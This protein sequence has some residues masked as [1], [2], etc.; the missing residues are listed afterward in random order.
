[1]PYKNLEKRKL[2]HRDYY[3]DYMSNQGR[4]YREKSNQKRQEEIGGYKKDLLL[5][6]KFRRIQKK[7]GIEGLKAFERDMFSCSLCGEWDFRVLEMHELCK[8]FNTSSN[9]RTLCSNCHARV[10]FD[11]GEQ[12]DMIFPVEYWDSHFMRVAEYYGR[13]SSCFSQKYG[14]V[15]VNRDEFNVPY[16]VSIGRNGPPIGFPHCN[17][18]NPNQEEICSR[19]L[20]G[21]KSGEGL[22]FCPAAH[23]ESNAITFAAREGRCTDQSTLYGNFCIPCKNCSI[24]IIQAG[25]KEIVIIEDREYQSIGIKS[26][27]LLDGVGIKIRIIDEVKIKENAYKIN[28]E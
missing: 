18:R 5:E 20:M 2:Y 4:I 17:L 8:P 26:K 3:R 14:A 19:R 13:N 22:E 21:Y 6:Y 24:D 7:Y 11:N 9:L 12:R 23:A 28:G 10:T 15:I 25:I 27:D 16:I 1:M